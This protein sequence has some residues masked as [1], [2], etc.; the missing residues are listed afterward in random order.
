MTRDA[1]RER[2]DSGDTRH[3]DDAWLAH[4]SIEKIAT[5]PLWS[6]LVPLTIA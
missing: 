1:W 5:T 6:D 4:F 2:V 3:D